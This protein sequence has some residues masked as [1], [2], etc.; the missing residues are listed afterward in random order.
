MVVDGSP[1]T[2]LSGSPYEMGFA[3]GQL[4]SEV[5]PQF[6]DAVWNYILVQVV[7]EVETIT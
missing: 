5:A 2:L 1:L 4:M 3:Q 6:F 7:S